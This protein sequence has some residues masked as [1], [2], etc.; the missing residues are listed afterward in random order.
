[1]RELS[2]FDDSNP[3]RGS[4]EHGAMRFSFEDASSFGE[5]Y[6]VNL[7]A[8]TFGSGL[9]LQDSLPRIYGFETT[10]TGAFFMKQSAIK[11]LRLAAFAAAFVLAACAAPVAFADLDWDLGRDY[12]TTANPNGDWTYGVYLDDSYSFPFY[13]W[14]S[15]QSWQGTA[16][17]QYW[18]NPG[19]DLG[20]GAIFDNPTE[21]LF[22]SGDHWMR[23][24]DVALYPAGIGDAYAPAIRWT[25]SADMTVSIDA[26]FTG[27]ANATTDVHILLNGDMLNGAP[28]AFT[29]THLFDG[30]IDGNYGCPEAGIPQTGASP[31]QAYAG[32]IDVHAGDTID[33]VV[34]YGSDL[35]YAS[36]M[37][38]VSAKITQVPEPG[39]LIV[40]A[41]GL[42]G[43]LVWRKR[44]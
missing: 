19:D 32:T 43:L 3:R 33:F 24:G 23:P 36:D 21:T 41:T 44:K 16:N 6:L 18:G 9:F 31:S 27:H 35:W 17:F 10:S 11:P 29:G 28:P 4:G 39:A 22:A 20:A 8:R 38:G 7:P 5:I 37:T 26:L 13:A 15:H 40:L 34:G 14:V 25:A 30:I 1:M 2:L 12:S 42:L